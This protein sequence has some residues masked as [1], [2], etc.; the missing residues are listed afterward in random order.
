M[1]NFGVF[2]GLLLF[3]GLS[4]QASAALKSH[5]V[6]GICAPISKKEKISCPMDDA[7]TPPQEF[8]Y[9]SFS[10]KDSKKVKT[11][12]SACSDAMVA[13]ILKMNGDVA[14][15]AADAKDEKMSK[16]M[17]FVPEA[18]TLLSLPTGGAQLAIFEQR[19]FEKDNG[20]QAPEL[21]HRQILFVSVN[22]KG[23]VQKIVQKLLSK[24]TLHSDKKILK[25]HSLCDT[26]GDGQAEIVM[27]EE[28][29]VMTNYLVFKI[30]P[31]A[32]DVTEETLMASGGCRI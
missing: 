5:S 10:A 26:N 23:Q 14:P 8:T 21:M 22:N 9:Y 2:L 25:I 16:P 1:K 28:E 17:R 7:D 12:A 3:W 30:K 20:G 6:G 13:D 31:D 29:S 32:S 15:K 4:I 19:E 11:T 18:C 24:D 27:D